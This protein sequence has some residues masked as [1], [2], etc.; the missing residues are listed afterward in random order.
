MSKAVERLMDRKVDLKPSP[1][2]D[3]G[4]VPVD[5]K[6][7]LQLAVELERKANPDYCVVSWANQEA[8]MEIY[9]TQGFVATLDYMLKLREANDAEWDRAHPEGNEE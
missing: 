2:E 5:H 1:K 6:L 9:N 3:P 7:V 4:L 8:A